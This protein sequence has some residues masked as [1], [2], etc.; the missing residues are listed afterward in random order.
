[1]E[2]STTTGS[3]RAFSSCLPTGT[4]DCAVPVVLSGWLTICLVLSTGDELSPAWQHWLSLTVRW[5]CNIH[6]YYYYYYYRAIFHAYRCHRRRD[7]CN[8]TDRPKYREL[9]QIKDQTERIV[10]LRLSITNKDKQPNTIPRWA[11]SARIASSSI[12]F[13]YST[14]ASDINSN[15]KQHWQKDTWMHASAMLV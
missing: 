12:D 13:S 4:E 6:F 8:R 1:M 11:S 3:G 10:A 15:D 7:I 14:C 2:H 9:Q 5:S